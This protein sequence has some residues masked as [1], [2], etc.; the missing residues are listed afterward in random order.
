MS[1]PGDE[2]QLSMLADLRSRLEELLARRAAVKA[3]INRLYDEERELSVRSWAIISAIDRL[4]GGTDFRGMTEPKSTPQMQ[5]GRG[6]WI[7]RNL[8]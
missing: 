2:H 8:A 3:E 7:D 6:S 4:G 1:D 5:D